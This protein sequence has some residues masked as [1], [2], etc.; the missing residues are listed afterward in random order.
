M[1]ERGW[2]NITGDPNTF[3]NTTGMA[4]TINAVASLNRRGQE[5]EKVASILPP[6]ALLASCSTHLTQAKQ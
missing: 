2:T 1:R 4:T 6:S 3:G 5:K